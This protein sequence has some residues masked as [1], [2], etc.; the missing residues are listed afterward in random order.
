MAS[1]FVVLWTHI[2]LRLF[3]RPFLR[4]FRTH[5]SICGVN[6]RVSVAI[7]TSPFAFRV[8]PFAFL[9]SLSFSIL[10][11]SVTVGDRRLGA[12]RGV[13]VETEEVPH[14]PAYQVR[15]PATQTRQ[16]AKATRHARGQE[17]H[18]LVHPQAP[19]APERGQEAAEGAEGAEGVEGAYARAT[20][21]KALAIA[22]QRASGKRATRSCS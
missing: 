13:V 11:F 21:T 4:L 14:R 18:L 12:V 8:S 16:H 20:L 17:P 5:A 19:R 1:F 15:V 22:M 7:P 3:L 2:C 10:S 9:V 6:C